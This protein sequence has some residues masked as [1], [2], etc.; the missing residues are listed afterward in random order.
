MVVTL[1]FNRF[2]SCKKLLANLGE[3]PKVNFKSILSFQ[4]FQFIPHDMNLAT[5]FCLKPPTR[6]NYQDEVLFNHWK[7]A[8]KQYTRIKLGDM[9]RKKTARIA[10]LKLSIVLMCTSETSAMWLQIPFASFWSI[11]LSQAHIET[12]TG[13]NTCCSMVTVLTLLSFRLWPSHITAPYSP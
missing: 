9:R 7:S 10:F 13:W 6:T 8:S 2:V 11:S 4:D 3:Y 5:K 1:R 12:F